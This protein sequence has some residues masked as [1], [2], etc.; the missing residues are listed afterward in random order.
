[1]YI[2]G[3]HRIFEKIIFAKVSLAL[4]FSLASRG[5][6]SKARAGWLAGWL[7]AIRVR[8]VRVRLLP[9]HRLRSFEFSRNRTYILVVLE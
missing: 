1:M 7:I 9:E 2:R 4:L 8:P 6:R 3:D 5:A